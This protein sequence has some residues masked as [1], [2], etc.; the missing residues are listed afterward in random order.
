MR[1]S[2]GVRCDIW[3]KKN[4]PRM[5]QPECSSKRAPV[6]SSSESSDLSLHMNLSPCW[7]QVYVFF[8][9]NARAS[10]RPKCTTQA[11]TFTH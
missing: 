1:A 10:G 5:L 4:G 3:N 6:H 2:A 7:I 11:Q 8:G 9:L